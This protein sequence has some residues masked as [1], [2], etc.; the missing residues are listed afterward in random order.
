MDTYARRAVREV[1][2]NMTD[3]EARLVNL[4]DQ[5]ACGAS[6]SELMADI[7]AAIAELRLG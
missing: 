7:E 5:V 2:V 1:I 4:R 6:T 3:I